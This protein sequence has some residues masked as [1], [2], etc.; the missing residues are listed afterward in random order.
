LSAPSDLTLP[1]RDDSGCRRARRFAESL[2]GLT[3]AILLFGMMCVTVVDVVGRYFLSQPL[4]GAYELTEIMLAMAV[5]IALPLVCLREEHVSVT[6]LTD[7]M[8]TRIRQIH[9]VVASLIGCVTFGI[10]AWQLFVHARRLASYGDVTVFLR[11]PKGPLGYA[12]ATC[13]ALAGIAL[14]LVAADHFVNTRQQARA[15]RENP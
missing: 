3:V 8:P 2:L 11:I 9:G 1:R 13:A 4:P 7:R 6:M 10:V 5:F 15:A 12:M 14:L